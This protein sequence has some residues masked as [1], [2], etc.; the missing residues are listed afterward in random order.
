MKEFQKK[1]SDSKANWNLRQEP[2]SYCFPFYKP[3]FPVSKEDVTE[4][5]IKNINNKSAFEQLMMDEEEENETGLDKPKPIKLLK[6]RRK[7]YKEIE[8]ENK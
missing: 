7:N 6:F 2:R 8:R 3:R 4:V 5:E 1:L